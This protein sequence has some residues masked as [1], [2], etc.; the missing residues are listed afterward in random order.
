MNDYTTINGNMEQMM[1]MV[2]QFNTTQGANGNMNGYQIRLAVMEHSLQ[3]LWNDY[4]AKMG[5]YEVSV[6]KDGDEVVTEVTLPEIPGTE[7]VLKTAEQ[8][9]SFINGGQNK[10]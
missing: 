2:P 8:L 10:K 4:S 3:H 5:Q 9:Y 6:K 7:M 1:K